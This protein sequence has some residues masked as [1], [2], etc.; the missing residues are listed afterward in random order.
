MS[1]PGDTEWVGMG[2]GSDLW[3]WQ[4]LAWVVVIVEPTGV[5][6]VFVNG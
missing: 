4:W 5:I 1:M 6:A 3:P 2:M